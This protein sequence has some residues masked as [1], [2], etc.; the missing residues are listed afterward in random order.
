MLIFTDSFFVYFYRF[1]QR[2]I[3]LIIWWPRELS[4]LHLLNRKNSYPCDDRC[5]ANTQKTNKQTKKM[6][7][8]STDDNRYRCCLGKNLK[9][10]GNRMFC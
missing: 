9:C 6:H 1:T 8:Q 4:A 7:A 2:Q 3:N 5:T 10:D